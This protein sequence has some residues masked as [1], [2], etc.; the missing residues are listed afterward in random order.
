MGT[1]PRGGGANSPSL[2]GSSPRASDAWGVVTL[3]ARGCVTL[4][5]VAPGAPPRPALGCPPHVFLQWYVFVLTA[6]LGVSSGYLGSVVM[7]RAPGAVR[8]DEGEACGMLMV[9]SLVG[10]LVVGAFAG[11]IWLL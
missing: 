1:V 9:L 7:M 10:G 8:P 5:A 4:C 11:W 6:A 2:L 3:T